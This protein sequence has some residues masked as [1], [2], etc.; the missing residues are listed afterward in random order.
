MPNSSSPLVLSP[1]ILN[2]FVSPN[3]MSNPS[4]LSLRSLS[5]LSFFI[6]GDHRPLDVGCCVTFLAEGSFRLH[7]FSPIN[8]QVINQMPPFLLDQSVVIIRPFKTTSLAFSSSDLWRIN[9]GHSELGP[10]CMPSS[11]GDH[12]DLKWRVLSS[13]WLHSDAFIKLLQI[14]RLE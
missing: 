9:L 8:P 11:E 14:Y 12:Q 5:L 13:S 10:D 7:F 4:S 6:A 1:P 3:P 2:P